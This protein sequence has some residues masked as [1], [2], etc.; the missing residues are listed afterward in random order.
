M[1]KPFDEEP[2]EESEPSFFVIEDSMD[3][4]GKVVLNLDESVYIKSD[5][6]FTTDCFISTSDV[7]TE[8]CELTV[9]G[10]FVAYKVSVGGTLSIGNNADVQ[11]VLLQFFWPSKPCNVRNVTGEIVYGAMYDLNN[12]SGPVSMNESVGGKFYVPANPTRNG[13]TFKGWTISSSWKGSSVWTSEMDTKLKSLSV[14]KDSSGT[15]VDEPG[16]FPLTITAEWVL[17]PT[18]TPTPKPSSGFSDVQDPK[19]AYYKAIYWAADAGITKGY[20][21]GTFGIDKN[22]TRGEMMMFLWRYAGKQEPKAVSK[23]PFKDVPKTHTFYK[24]I[25]WGSQKGITKGYSDGTFGVNRNVTRGEC[26]MFL[27]RLKNK[28]APKAV[29]KAPFP[30]VPKNHVFYN[31]VL[32]GYQKKI[33]TGFTSGP[34]KGKFGVDENC[35]RGQ[36]VTFLYRAR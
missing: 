2:E 35:S 16:M 3:T 17:P 4:T 13:Y 14:K 29:A 28:P 26:M 36:I 15:Y 9:N 32:W 1:K 19:H 34:L 30:D 6:S 22:C 12:G 31:A 8:D 11:V 23:S 10:L 21:D 33:T 24:A 18:P 27:W 20:P 7:L 25:L 5:V